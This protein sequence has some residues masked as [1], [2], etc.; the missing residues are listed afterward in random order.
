MDVAIAT[1]RALPEPDADETLYKAALTRAGLDA[2]VLAWDDPD[3]PFADATTVVIRSTWNYIHNLDRYLAWVDAMGD[4]LINPRAMVRWNAHKQYLLDLEAAGVPVVPTLLARR[5]EKLPLAAAMIERGWAEVVVKP[6]VSAGSFETR[7]LKVPTAD[8]IAWL[9]GLLAARDMLVQ[10]Y[11]ASV[12]GYGERS[13]VTID[14]QVTHAIRKNPRFK[15]SHE[16]VS[17]GALPVADDERALAAKAL[18][19]ARKYGDPMYGRVDMARD[20]TNTPVIMELEMIEPSLF[21]PQNPPAADAW[22]QAI[23]KRL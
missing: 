2:R 13:L 20:A 4:K 15:D 10:P 19:V 3:A 6:A 5:G 7:R 18:A 9:D 17:T 23:K 22:A 8:D 14:G 11:V 1:C 16:A 21:F 12:E